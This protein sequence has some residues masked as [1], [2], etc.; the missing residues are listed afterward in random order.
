MVHAVRMRDRARLV[1]DQRERILALLNVF[2]ALEPAVDLLRGDYDQGCAF[3]LEFV[4]GRLQLS[5][6]VIAVRSPGSADEDD[7]ERFAGVVR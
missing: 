3:F 7:D 4:V 2:S 5:Q 6:L 1:E